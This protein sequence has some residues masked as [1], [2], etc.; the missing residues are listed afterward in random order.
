MKLKNLAILLTCG[1]GLIGNSSIADATFP[2]SPSEIV[3]EAPD[4]DWVNIADDDLV[5]ITLSNGKKFSFQLASQ[6]APIHVNNI[7]K[8]IRAGWFDKAAVNRVQDNYVVQWGAPENT[9]TPENI[10]QNPPSE[11]DF[12]LRGLPFRA[13]PYRDAYAPQTGHTNSWPMASNGRNAWLVH[14]YGMIG[15]ARGLAPDTGNGGELYSII[16]HSPRHLDRNITIVGR[17]VS[18][19]ENITALPRGTGDLGFYV[20]DDQ[21]LQFKEVKLASDLPIDERPHYQVM[22][23][24]SPS[25]ASWLNA[26][27]NRGGPFFT[28]PA[29]AVDICNAQAPIREK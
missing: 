29:G 6:F 18:G 1:L 28:K 4:S 26:R 19:M 11:Y 9:P 14:C 27:A 16:G 24:N 22:R 2:K 17:I 25:F 23:N 13:T 12:P 15:V 8:F 20:S 5:I 7:K 10:V 21:K 3:Q